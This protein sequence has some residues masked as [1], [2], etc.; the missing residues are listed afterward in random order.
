MALI[1]ANTDVLIDYLAGVPGIVRR[2]T[3]YISSDQLGTSAINCFELMSGARE[4]QRGELVRRLLAALPILPLDRAAAERA[5]GVRRQLEAMGR[6]I[7]VAD[8]LVAG[9][10][11]ANDVALI[12]RNRTHFDGV[13]DLELVGLDAESR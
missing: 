8:S 13:A 5:A 1:L 10:A 2:L 4:G 12:T 3:A 7:G 11:L 9:I 6:T